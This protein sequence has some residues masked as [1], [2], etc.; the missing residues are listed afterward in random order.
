MLAALSPASTE[1]RPPNERGDLLGSPAD[2]PPLT[3]DNVIS[4]L[5]G[6]GLI[7]SADAAT[8]RVLTGGIS[9]SVLVVE[10]ATARLVVKRALPFLRVSEYWAASP[11]RAQTEARALRLAGHLTPGAVP[12]VIDDDPMTH[13]LVIEMASPGWEVWKTQLMSGEINAN[14]ARELGETLGT[15]HHATAYVKDVATQFNE[16]EVFDQ[17]RVDPFYRT[18]QRRK[19]TLARAV[20]SFADAMEGRKAVLVHGDFSP[21]NVLIMRDR[22][23][24]V[25]FEVAHYGD[26]A[27]DPAYCLNHLLLKSIHNPSLGANYELCGRSFWEAY[28]MTARDVAP[29][30]EYLWGHV[31]CQM[32]ARVIGKSPAEYL[33]RS[34]REAALRA[35][36]ALVTDPP[37]DLPSAWRLTQHFIN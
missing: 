22:L 5:R 32:L 12:R 37:S 34:Q 6:R 16:W 3:R 1:R 11:R 14:I 30:S 28:C 10:T 13:T 31:G 36:A 33:S 25:D 18:V 23:W 19:P 35:G 15:W 8:I 9:N 20:G 7:R 21:K 27:F 29:Q 24:V 4:Y 2:A 26:A 17:L